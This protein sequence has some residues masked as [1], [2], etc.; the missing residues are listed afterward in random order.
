MSMK[1][2][3]YRGMPFD[4]YLA[5]DAFSNS[6]ATALRRS[7]AHL[8]ASLEQKPDRDC[9]RL[10]SAMH[11]YALEGETAFCASYC[12]AGQC[13]AMKKD[14]YRCDNSGTLRNAGQWF[15]GVHG[16]TR[17]N[18]DAR[19]VLKPEEFDQV[20]GM[21]NACASHPMLG[22]LLAD[23]EGFR[24]VTVLWLC[25]LTGILCKARPD[26]VACKREPW[27][28][29]DLKST[30]DARRNA[31]MKSLFQFGY[32]TQ[33]AHY[34]EGLQLNGVT[35]NHFVFGAVENTPP[36]ACQP[37]R[38]EDDVVQA[39]RN[40]LARLKVLYA[41]CRE[42][43]EWPAYSD[44]IESITLPGYAWQDLEGV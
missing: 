27:V 18:D 11:T 15:C 6:M 35:V 42:T 28:V 44:Q 30:R 26:A 39:G 3:I 32:F 22:K 29:P 8:K 20:R 7:P 40:E 2:G 5:I 25:P 16:K 33:A 17:V 19:L 34:L 9:F 21:G 24:E 43:N 10:G 14:G 1:P 41:R 37:Y 23:S 31:F 36:Y 13:S 12:I 4:E 38:I